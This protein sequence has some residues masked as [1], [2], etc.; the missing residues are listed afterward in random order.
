MYGVTLMNTCL[1]VCG[2]DGVND[3]CHAL[4]FVPANVIMLVTL[5]PF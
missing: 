3:V 1:I 4:I 5:T 2:G